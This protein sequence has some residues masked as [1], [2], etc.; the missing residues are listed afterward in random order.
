[1]SDLFGL[2]TPTSVFARRKRITRMRILYRSQY[3]PPETSGRETAPAGSPPQHGLGSGCCG[4]G[5]GRSNLCQT[6]PART[7]RPRQQ[8]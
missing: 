2:P 1:V 6:G 8:P 5:L 4:V 7:Y 3:F